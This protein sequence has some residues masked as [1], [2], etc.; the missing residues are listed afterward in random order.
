M[1]VLAQ[2]GSH[3]V[4]RAFARCVD[5]VVAG[6]AAR[7]DV[8]VIEV[9]R[10]PCNCRMAVVAVMAGGNMVRMFSRRGN[11]V[12]TASAAAQN[13]GVVDEDHGLPC[14]GAVA[15]FAHVR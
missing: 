11:A 4:H 10:D 3:C 1:A 12:V 8:R 13:L 7:H 9:R 15:V 14:T 5:A 2:V 6:R